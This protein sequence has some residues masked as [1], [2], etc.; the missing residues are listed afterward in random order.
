MDIDTARLVG[1][2]TREI[3]TREYEGKPARVLVA[4]R[5]FGPPIDDGF[6]DRRQT[7]ELG[8]GKILRMARDHVSVLVHDHQRGKREPV[9]LV[10]EQV[11]A[12]APVDARCDVRKRDHGL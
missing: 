12:C 5:C 2:V 1:T 4:S 11:V 10:R 9:G 3:S 8:N 7:L 6:G